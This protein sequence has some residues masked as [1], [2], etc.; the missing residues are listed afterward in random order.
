[1]PVEGPCTL[2]TIFTAVFC[3]STTP[4]LSE[5]PRVFLPFPTLVVCA[6]TD[7]ASRVVFAAQIPHNDTCPILHVGAVEAHSELLDQWK[8]VQVVR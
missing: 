6:L 7:A 1:M 5:L 8:D 3:P 2:L 4:T